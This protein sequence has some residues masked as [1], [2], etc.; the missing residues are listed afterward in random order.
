MKI[1][2]SKM[3][4]ELI[5]KKAG[6]VSAKTKTCPKCKGEKYIQKGNVVERCPDCDEGKVKAS[7]KKTVKIA[8]LSEN[9]VPVEQ[10]LGTSPV[11]PFNDDEID[12]EMHSK[13]YF[14]YRENYWFGKCPSYQNKNGDKVI[15]NRGWEEED[16]KAKWVTWEQLKRVLKDQWRPVGREELAW[17]HQNI[18]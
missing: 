14:L 2:L 7:T 1:K 8:E 5:G 12:R 4:W 10:I 11:H 17:Y 15:L 6:W 3:Q 18:G 9:V 16:G 13:G